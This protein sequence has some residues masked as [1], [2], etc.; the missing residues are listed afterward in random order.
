MT[1]SCASVSPCLCGESLPRPARYRPRFCLS[2]FKSSEKLNAR[3][4]FFGYNPRVPP[5]AT[6]KDRKD[7]TRA[8]RR[9]WNGSCQIG[10]SPSVR[11]SPTV[12]FP[13]SVLGSIRSSVQRVR[14]SRTRRPARGRGQG[15]SVT[16]RRAL[17]SR[18]QSVFIPGQQAKSEYAFRA[19][20]TAPRLAAAASVSIKLRRER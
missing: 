15:S 6:Q 3:L 1:L 2:L 12:K 19:A 4:Q 10:F 20:R 11:I 7:S 9:R 5:A 16:A 18:R 14:C 13:S 8:R 17:S